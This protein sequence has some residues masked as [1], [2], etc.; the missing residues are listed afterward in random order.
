[1]SLLSGPLKQVIAKA[2]EMPPKIFPAEQ[3][4]EVSPAAQAVQNNSVSRRRARKLQSASPL[5][6]QTTLL[7]G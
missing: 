3:A 2:K 1:M 5:N 7:G 6:S 4:K